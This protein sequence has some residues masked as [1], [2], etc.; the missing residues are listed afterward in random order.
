MTGRWNGHRRKKRLSAS[1]WRS[2]RSVDINPTRLDNPLWQ[3]MVQ[4]RRDAYSGNNEFGGPPP[5][6][7]GPM[8]C[9]QRFGTSETALPDGRTVHIAGE[10]EDSY[11]P[12]FQIYNDVIVSSPDGGIAIYGYPA[13]AIYIIGCLG[14]PEQRSAGATPVYRLD[15]ASMQILAVETSGMA[16]GR[17]A[18]HSGRLSDGGKT[19]IVSGGEIWTG[20][21]HATMKNIDS[22]S[23]EIADGEWRRLTQYNW[24]HWIVR[25]TDLQRMRIWDTRQEQ[26]RANQKNFGFESYWRHA[27]FPNFAA[28]QMLYRL[29]Q[30][31]STGSYCS[32]PVGCAAPCC[33]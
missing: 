9:F 28:P 5:F 27:E 15:L 3:W 14:Y 31:G 20:A 10:H 8:W 23:F 7:C 21:E 25:R 32:R 24:P 19:I 22:W 30:D 6:E 13:N 29:D 26:W 17:I 33:T 1:A 4:T 12:D 11:D 2:P 16:P 18:R